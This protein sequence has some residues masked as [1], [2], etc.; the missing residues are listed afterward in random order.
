MK[1]NKIKHGIEPGT[2]I[3]ERQNYGNIGRWAEEV[4]KEQGHNVTNSA[5]CDLPDYG[6]EIKTRKVESKSPH[7]VGTMSIHDIIV[8]PYPESLICEKFQTQYRVHYSDEGQVVL[9]SRVY[10]LT[11]DFFQSKIREAY[12]AGRK[13]IAENEING[14]H[15]PYVKGT[16]W[17][18]FEI[19]ESCSAY[20]FR[21]PHGAMKKIETAVRNAKNFRNFFE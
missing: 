14:Y 12:E 19:T 18:N 4:M 8:T 13:R 16:E 1:V 10:D 9:D 7:T 11:D 17:G 6:V 20:R 2:Q 5:G 3:P 15:P 21:I